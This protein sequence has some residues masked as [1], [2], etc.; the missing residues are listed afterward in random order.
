MLASPAEAFNPFKRED[1][2]VAA[3]NKLFSEGKFD[4]ALRAYEDAQRELGPSAELAYDR[5][6]ALFKLGRNAEAREAYLSALTATDT[7]LNRE[8]AIKVLP[9]SSRKISTA[10]PDSPAMH[11]CSPRSTVRISRPSTPEY[12]CSS[13][14]AVIHA[15]Q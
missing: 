14:M 3:G 8:V 10:W 11:N 2:H 7:K 5:G 13:S 1:P 15:A 12:E 6:N 4:E 9:E